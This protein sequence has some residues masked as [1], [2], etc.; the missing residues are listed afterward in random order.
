LIAVDADAMPY[1]SLGMTWH[2]LHIEIKCSILEA[3]ASY[4][5]YVADSGGVEKEQK[6]VV[7]ATNMR[8]TFVHPGHREDILEVLIDLFADRDDVRQGKMFAFPSF[9]TG[10]KI[11]ASVFG[12]GVSLKLPPETIDRLADDE[13][14]SFVPMGKTMTG[15]VLITRPEAESYRDDVNLFN[16][17]IDYVAE[18]ARERPPRPRKKAAKKAKR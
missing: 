15:W 7:S 17:S 12:D 3:N 9:S 6:T 11:F 8:E 13:I 2:F 10:G 1:E 4:V 14:T 18:L 16:I 5:H